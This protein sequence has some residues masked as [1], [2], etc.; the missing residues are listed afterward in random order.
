M[1][2]DLNYGIGVEGKNLVLKTLGRVYVKVKDRKYELIFR[3]EDLQKMVEDYAG[4]N[5]GSTGSSSVMFIDSSLDIDNL[6]YPGDN[7]LVISK[8]GHIYFTENNEYTEIYLSISD[9][10]VLKSLTI[11]DVLTFDNNSNPIIFSGKTFV[12]NL[13]ANY[14]NGYQSS[15]FLLKNIINPQQINGSITCNGNNIYNGINTYTNK[16]LGISEDYPTTVLDFKT[17]TL[18]IDKIN[19]NA[20]NISSNNDD[21]NYI[22]GIGSEVWVN[23]EIDF[24]SSE[25]LDSIFSIDLGSIVGLA[26]DLKYLPNENETDSISLEFWTDLFLNDGI[27]RDF[28]NEFVIQEANQKLQNIGLQNFNNYIDVYYSCLSLDYSNFSGSI[29]RI[30]F[31]KEYLFSDI[32]INKLVKY[33]NFIGVVRYID[34]EYCIIQFESEFILPNSGFVT[35]IGSLAKEGGIRFSAED[36]SLAILKNVLDETSAAIYFGELSKIDN[37]KSGI[38][39]ILSGTYPT[40]VVADNTLNNLRNYQHTSEINIENPYLKW[41]NNIT[42]FNEDG[43][44]YLSKGQIRWSSNNDLIVDGSDISNSRI[45]NTGITNSSFQSGNILINTDGSGNIGDKIQFNS[46]TVTLNSPIGPAGGDLE[47]NYPNPTLAQTYKDRISALETQVS[48]LE[49][50]VTDLETQTSNLQYQLQLANNNISTLQ[51]QNTEFE[52]R[53]EALEARP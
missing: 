14:L 51:R 12:Q 45:T 2:V 47:G 32:Y 49:N 22:R 38:G 5:S 8:D 24:I 34:S 31:S 42:I 27:L 43:S 11:S 18:T 3:P 17:S 15:E 37:N 48:D 7:A 29:I 30:N 52:A 41:G 10:L 39:M 28:K 25:E 35:V 9:E 21:Q 20:I 16:I 6:E 44:G 33:N 26:Y 19:A 1:A 40:N 46:T 13:D 4:E 23:P 36:P 50:K 53:I